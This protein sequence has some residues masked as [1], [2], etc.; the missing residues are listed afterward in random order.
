M[1]FSFD[2]NLLN[3]ASLAILAQQLQNVFGDLED[4]LNA[5]AKIQPDLGQG[6]PRNAVGDLLISQDQGN[7]TFKFVTSTDSSVNITAGP[8]ITD[9]NLHY[10]GQKTSALPPSANEFPSDG[11]WGFHTDSNLSKLYLSMNA[12]GTIKKVELT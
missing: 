10:L 9:L 8:T 12:N 7:I 3:P 4:S 5:E 2:R 6:F 11:D 1:G